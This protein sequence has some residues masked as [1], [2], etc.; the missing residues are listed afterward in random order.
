[1]SDP[2][3]D[4]P[5]NRFWQYGNKTAMD[6]DQITRVHWLVKDNKDYPWKVFFKDGGS[7]LYSEEAGKALLEAWKAYRGVP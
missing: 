6:L 1:M 7:M 5:S 4:A 2:Y 3:R